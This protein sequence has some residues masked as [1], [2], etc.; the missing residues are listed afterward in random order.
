VAGMSCLP[1][2]AAC[3]ADTQVIIRLHKARL[4]GRCPRLASGGRNI[5]R[6][7]Q[8]MNLLGVVVGETYMSKGRLALSRDSAQTET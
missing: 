8:L 7:Y 1:V 4:G 3:L 6:L 2:F 5:S